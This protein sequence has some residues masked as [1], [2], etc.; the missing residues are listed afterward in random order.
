M[1]SIRK[2]RLVLLVAIIIVI[3]IGG[4]K[5]KIN[6]GKTRYN[7]SRTVVENYFKYWDEKNREMILTTLTK[8]HNSPKVGFSFDNIENVKLLNVEEVKDHPLKSKYISKGVK[9]E[10][11]TVLKVKFRV[12]VKKGNKGPW[13]SREYN[14]WFFLIRENDNSNWLIDQSGV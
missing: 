8:W 7:E 6:Q 1:K 10:N 3:C 12:E 4:C 14:H 2:I 11:I 13:E 5:W 9:D